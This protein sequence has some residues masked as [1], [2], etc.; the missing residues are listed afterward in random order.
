MNI[1]VVTDSTSDLPQAL[2]DEYGISVIPCF[3][4]I[5][6]ESYLDGV[7]LSREE[8]YRRLP[9]YTPPPTT[10]APGIGSFV[11][12]YRQLIADGATAIISVHVSARLSN[13]VN[14]AR[15]AAESITE[16][17]VHVIDSGQVT[18]GTGL[19][20]LEAAKAAVAEQVLDDIVTAIQ[21]EG[22]THLHGGGAEYAGVSATQRTSVAVPGVDGNSDEHQAAAYDVRW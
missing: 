21:R 4:N 22:E 1:K 11:D 10:S 9:D 3:I 5:G 17:P 6:D 15:L 20:A 12:K 14:V 18:I 13:V 19:L 16:V 2:V 8:F 7:E